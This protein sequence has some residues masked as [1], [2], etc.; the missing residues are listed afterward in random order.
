[1]RRLAQFA[2]LAA[3]TALAAGAARAEPAS[4]L[5]GAEANQVAAAHAHEV[6]SCY[7]RHVLIEPRASGRVRV[8]LEVRSDGGVARARVDAPGV[9][10]R[11]LERC[12]VARA[13]SWRF[14]ASSAPTEVRM[15]FY[16]QVPVRMRAARALP[17]DT[18]PRRRDR[19]RSRAPWWSIR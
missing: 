6:K 14:P 8:E 9:V 5:T 16:F 18:R 19:A 15:P 4:L 7:F 2:V 10:R 13:L 17:L 3:L 11:A 1:M 12:V